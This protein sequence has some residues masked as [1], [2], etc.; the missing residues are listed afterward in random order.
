MQSAM[1]RLSAFVRERRKLVFAAWIVLL[2]ASVPFASRQTVNLTS[3]GFEVPGTQSAVVDKEVARFP[4]VDQEPLGVVLE[5]RG[6]DMQA[7]V[8]RVADAADGV[9]NAALTDEARAT[10]E[11]AAGQE[12]VVLVSLDPAGTREDVLQASKDLRE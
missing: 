3:G 10:A 11:A 6:G 8:A 5:N 2:L 9:E 12:E 4:D 7:A 1:N